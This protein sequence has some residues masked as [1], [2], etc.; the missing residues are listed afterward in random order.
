MCGLCACRQ[1]IQP[2]G[3]VPVVSVCL[4]EDS[5]CGYITIIVIIYSIGTVIVCIMGTV[6]ALV[7]DIY[8]YTS[9]YLQC[10]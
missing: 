1:G 3:N 6:V 7:G 10:S 8:Q 4:Y 5:T 2:P 9:A